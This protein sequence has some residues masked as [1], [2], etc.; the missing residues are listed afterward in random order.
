MHTHTHTPTHLHTYIVIA[1]WHT[2]VLYGFCVSTSHSHLS[3]S[4]LLSPPLSW[5]VSGLEDQLSLAQEHRDQFQSMSQANEEALQEMT[6]T[7]EEVKTS[8]ELQLQTIK[9]LPTTKHL[10]MRAHAHLFVYVGL[11][12]ACVWNCGL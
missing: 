9:V 2:H 6:R 1:Y 11:C 5:Q 8:L 12:V 7:A 10:C 3:R 4:V